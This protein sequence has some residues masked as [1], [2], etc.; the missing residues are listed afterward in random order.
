MS[1]NRHSEPLECPALSAG[2]AL[3]MVT[4]DVR[5]SWQTEAQGQDKPP[6]ALSPF[7]RHTGVVST[8]R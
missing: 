8:R 2:G 7:H 3:P 1:L 4:Y 6:L 5:A